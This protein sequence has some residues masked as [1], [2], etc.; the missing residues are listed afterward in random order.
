MYMRV[1][2]ICLIHLLLLTSTL[3]AKDSCFYKLRADFVAINACPDQDIGLY[4]ISICAKKHIA[5]N[6]DFGDGRTSTLKQPAVKYSTPNSLN[7]IKLTLTDSVSLCKD[8]IVKFIGVYAKPESRFN[9]II[10]ELDDVKFRQFTAFNTSINDH[11]FTWYLPGG[12]SL[13]ISGKNYLLIKDTTLPPNTKIG[14]KVTSNDGCVAHSSADFDL[15][16]ITECINDN[17]VK[18]LGNPCHLK[19]DLTVSAGDRSYKLYNLSGELIDAGI[20]TIGTNS[21]PL[22]ETGI[23]FIEILENGI[24]KGL[25]KIISE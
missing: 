4:N 11:C 7:K 16:G 23:F 17:K 25:I 10:K 18:L 9:C 1:K 19:A 12:D 21:I 20:L 24:N 3:S 14:L 6:W 13:V 2:I 22:T 15:V 5:Y 8:S